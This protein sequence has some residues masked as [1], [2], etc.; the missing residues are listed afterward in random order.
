MEK[1]IAFDCETGGITVDTSLLT[2][3]FIV[4]NHKFEVL[5]TL[6]LK[7]KPNNK[8]PYVVTAEALGINGINLVEHDKLA[9]TESEAGGKLREF[10]WK[11]SENGKARLV[12][13]GHNVGFDEDFIHVHLL[14]KKEYSKYCSYRKLDTSVV[15]QYLKAQG[16]LPESITGS[17]TSLMEHFGLKFQGRAH[18]ADSDTIGTVEVLKKMLS[19]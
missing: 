6:D 4:M 3:Y 5:D 12:P 13:V 7:V 9:I 14:N 1:Y 19:M 17:L 2:A 18:D 10:L 8:A 16:K 15:A 11:N